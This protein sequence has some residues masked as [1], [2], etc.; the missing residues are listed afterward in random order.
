MRS[1]IAIFGLAS[2]LVC[3]ASITP[4]EARDYKYC[5]MGDFLDYPGDCMYS[6]MAQCQ[7]SA[8]G[9]QA[10]CDINPRYAFAMQ[11]QQRR[12]RGYRAP[13]DRW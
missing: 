9:R 4:S 2:V 5:L 1:A 12:A 6:T 7:A 8:S 11:Q 3:L 10:Y 13:A